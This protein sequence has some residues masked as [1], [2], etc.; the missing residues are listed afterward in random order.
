MLNEQQQEIL[1]IS[2]EECAEVIQAIS[3][4]FR[5]GLNGTHPD[6][7]QDNQEHLSEEIGDLIAMIELLIR[8][9]IIKEDDVM[10]ARINKFK[11]L[12]KWSNIDIPEV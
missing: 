7:A 10:Q 11:K 3:K 6:R 2:Q 12:S 9:G 1:R 5:F 4:V 8:N